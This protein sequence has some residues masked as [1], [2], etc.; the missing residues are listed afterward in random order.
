MCKKIIFILEFRQNSTNLVPRFWNLTVLQNIR[1]LRL[2]PVCLV[3]LVLRCVLMYWNRLTP[4]VIAFFRY[5]MV[6]FFSS[7][8]SSVCFFVSCFFSS[9]VST[10]TLSHPSYTISLY[11]SL[12]V[13][14]Y[15]NLCWEPFQVLLPSEITK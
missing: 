9:F 1:S 7:F 10:E 3:V 2:P 6:C 14:R 15:T 4:L 5:I 13:H 12:N 8:F 11:Y